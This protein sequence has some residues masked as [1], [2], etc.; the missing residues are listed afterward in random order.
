MATVSVPARLRTMVGRAARVAGLVPAPV[1]RAVL[2]VDDPAGS[3]LTDV[4]V[5]GRAELGRD[6]AC[7]VA[8]DHPSVSWR[9]AALTPGPA[10]GWTVTDL[11]STNGT[12]VDG[13]RV[14]G[15][16]PLAPGSVLALGTDGPRLRLQ[17]PEPAA[18]A[19]ATATAPVASR[20]Y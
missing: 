7:E 17:V 15:P 13:A 1:A 20:G 11:G 6:P 14:T 12:T 5:D 18:R 10:G 4:D 2:V 19:D 3:P 8:V 9:H 16:T